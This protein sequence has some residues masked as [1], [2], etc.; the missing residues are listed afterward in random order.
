MNI[1]IRE[2]YVLM[3]YV[4]KLFEI[5]FIN[6]NFNTIQYLEFDFVPLD[7]RHAAVFSRSSRELGFE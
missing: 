2:S 1:V 3:F 5:I 6:F 4:F 7:I